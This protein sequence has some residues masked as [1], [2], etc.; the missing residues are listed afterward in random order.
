MLILSLP[1]AGVIWCLDWIYLDWSSWII[2]T[3]YKGFSD[4]PPTVRSHKWRHLRLI[5]KRQNQTNK[6]KFFRHKLWR[7]NFEYFSFFIWRVF[8]IREII[9]SLSFWESFWVLILKKVQGNIFHF[10]ICVGSKNM[11]Q[12]NWTQKSSFYYCQ[13]IPIQF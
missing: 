1:I 8:N 5:I 11:K 12:F 6:L 9:G 10:M 7:L 13:D 3:C 2:N 4:N